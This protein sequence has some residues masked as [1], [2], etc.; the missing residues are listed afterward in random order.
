L[1]SQRNPNQ[2]P[3]QKTLTTLLLIIG[4]VAPMAIAFFL[5]ASTNHGGNPLDKIPDYE[6]LPTETLVVPFDRGEATITQYEYWDNVRIVVEGT[7]QAGGTAYS[8]AFYLYTDANG[9]PLEIPQPA[10]FDLEIDGQRAIERIEGD[11]PPYNDAH[12]YAV[13][14]DAGPRARH[15]AFRISDEVVGDNTGSFTITVVQLKN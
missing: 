13:L 3:L 9:Q 8:D 10:M 2:S 15:L 6:T 11:P 14:V 5:V 4:S 1:S 12:L 7:G